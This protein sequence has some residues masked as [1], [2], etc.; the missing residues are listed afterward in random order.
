MLRRQS[1]ETKINHERWLVSYADFIT[2]LFAFFVVMYSVS[3]VS[4]KKYKVLSS[5]LEA[6]FSS[7]SLSDADREDDLHGDVSTNTAPLDLLQ[8]EF[9]EAFSGLISAGKITLSGNEQWVEIELNSN[10]LFGSASAD[11]SDTARRLFADVADIL[12][13]YDNAVA[14]SGHTDNVPIRN[15]RYESNW[16][17]SS[18]R[19][20]SVVNL[21]AYS[22]V[23]P[24]R[25]SAVGYGE[26]RPIADN[27]T[28]EGRGLNRRVVL[29]VAKDAV[30]ADKVDA[31]SLGD[32]AVDSDDRADEIRE[33]GTEELN[34]G[35][36]DENNV[37][38]DSVGSKSQ[39]SD[40]RS[41]IPGLAP[42]KLEGGGLLF[43]SDPDL[44]R[45]NSVIDE[46]Q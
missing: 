31:R 30:P 1:F 8:D 23:S 14:V 21:L 25:L 2:L 5:T 3:Q 11:A 39:P 6:A 32:E 28:E 20:V 15:A 42:V 40:V 34:N 29:R 33:V 41:E 24:E 12:A 19:A 45:N 17:L 35:D 27:T 10:I 37:T 16:A 26:Y 44:P 38:A 36:G 9:T 46:D 43:S 18:S 13:P 7:G 22:G 4:E